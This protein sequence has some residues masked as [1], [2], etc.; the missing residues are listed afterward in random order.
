MS[1]Y[2]IGHSDVDKIF[3]KCYA[4]C[5]FGLAKDLKDC[6]RKGIFLYFVGF[7]SFVVFVSNN[8]EN[9]PSEV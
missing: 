5:S 4:S 1:F 6:F 3:E 8:L 2:I 9:G 7:L